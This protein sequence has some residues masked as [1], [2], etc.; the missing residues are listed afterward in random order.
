MRFSR[1]YKFKK[2][3]TICG[4][5]VDIF[6]CT[7]LESGIDVGQGI[8]MASG[9]VGQIYVEQRSKTGK[10]FIAHGKKHYRGFQRSTIGPGKNRIMRNSYQLSSTQTNFH[11]YEFTNNR[12]HQ[13]EFYTYSTKNRTSGIRTSGDRTSGGPPVLDL[14]MFWARWPLQSQ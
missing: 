2:E 11:Q 8:N 10:I 4:N 14:G 7:T 1:F 13:Y 12:F 5:T 3:Q 9:K 6:W